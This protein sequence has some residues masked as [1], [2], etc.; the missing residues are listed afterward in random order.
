MRSWRWAKVC[1][2]HVE[3]ILEVNKTVIVASRWFLYYLTYI[4]DAR[5]NTNQVWPFVF[6]FPGQKFVCHLLATL[7]TDLHKCSCCNQTETGTPW[8]ACEHSRGRK[9]EAEK[10]REREREQ[11]GWNERRDVTRRQAA[12][13]NQCATLYRIRWEPYGRHF[14][15]YAHGSYFCYKEYHRTQYAMQNTVATSAIKTNIVHNM[16]CRTR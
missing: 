9:E 10:K 5:L 6:H 3:L 15:N 1:P 16:L 4:D 14:R 8:T 12:S 13:L 11:P 7:V 2:K